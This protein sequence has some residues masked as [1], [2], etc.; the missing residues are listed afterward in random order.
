MRFCFCPR[1]GSQP[2]ITPGC[3]RIWHASGTTPDPTP[4]FSSRPA[5]GDRGH[6]RSGVLQGGLDDSERIRNHN[7]DRLAL[8]LDPP[9]ERV[10]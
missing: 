6:G 5:E 7:A 1:D 2:L 10:N 9:I 3:H 8:S 4:A